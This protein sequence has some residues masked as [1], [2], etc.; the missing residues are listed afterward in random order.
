MNSKKN[1]ELGFSL[2]QLVWQHQLDSLFFFGGGVAAVDSLYLSSSA[3]IFSDYSFWVYHLV[4]WYDR[5]MQ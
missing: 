3:F 4:N 5:H 2:S 1:F